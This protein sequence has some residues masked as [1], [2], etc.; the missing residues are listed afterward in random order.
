MAS[1]EVD[2]H[3]MRGRRPMPKYMKL[4]TGNRG[5]RRI[6]DEYDIPV[7]P[8]HDNKLQPPQPLKGRHL[9]LWNKYVRKAPW[10]T[11]FDSP[12]AYLWVLLQETLERKGPAVL[13]A[14]MVNA[15][16]KLGGDLG[17]DPIARVRIS[18]PKDEDAEKTEEVNKKYF[19][20]S[21]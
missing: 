16:I 12:K 10:L 4:L 18:K 11:Y 7:D 17:F 1:G 13:R 3:L 14:S 20:A 21:A 9:Q 5:K 19:S 8:T 6:P 15:L 2:I